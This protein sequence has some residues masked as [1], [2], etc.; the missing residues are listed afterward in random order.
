MSHTGWIPFY[1]EAGE[2]PSV[3][4]LHSNASSSSQWRALM[5]RL[6][7]RFRVLAP[8]AFGSGKSPP[9]TAERRRSLSDELALA[10][11]VLAQAGPD[12]ALVGHSYGAALALVA[13]V[14]QPQR[15]KAMV[16]FE[17]TLFA[18]IDADSPSPNEADEARQVVV[19]RAG[20][21][22]AHEWAD[23]A[24]R[25][26]DYW[27]GEGAWASMPPERQGPIAASMVNLMDWG[28]ALMT[29]PTPLQAFAGLDCPVLYM[30]GQNST[31]SA[32]AV[33]RLLTAV[34]PQVEV[35][36]LANMGHMGPV[37]H[38]EQVNAEVER[39]LRHHLLGEA[40]VPP[41]EAPA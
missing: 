28:H 7:P 10:E 23:A 9:W 16:L 20:N 29:E 41:A 14:Q 2:G 1:R 3:V 21:L 34:L 26:I 37:T 24:Q 18:L 25:F 4:C 27:M 36:T 40:R 17:P 22:Q 31:R 35:L 33:A 12:F 5:T 39:F 32:K 8:D 15:V 11:P 6:A 19:A 13:A 38:A 30:L